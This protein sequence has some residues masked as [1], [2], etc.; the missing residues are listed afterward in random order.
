MPITSSEIVKMMIQVGGRYKVRESHTDHLGGKYEVYYIAENSADA[1]TVLGI[2]ASSLNLQ[3]QE[4]EIQQNL[5][6]AFLE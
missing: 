1:I 6:E 2:H 4:Q 3:L 5:N